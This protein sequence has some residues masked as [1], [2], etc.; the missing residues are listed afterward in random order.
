MF[1][2]LA[3]RFGG[4]AGTGGASHREYR[5]ILLGG[6]GNGTPGG[7]IGG[8]T[9]YTISTQSSASPITLLYRQ[10]TSPEGHHSDARP[11]TKGGHGAFIS[12][13]SSRPQ[14]TVSSVI[15]AVGG[16]GGNGRSPSVPSRVGGAG[17]G[18]VGADGNGNANSGGTQSSGGVGDRPTNPGNRQLGSSGGFLSAG[19]GGYNQ[20]NPVEQG[21]SGG[22][23]F[24]GGAGG[25]AYGMHQRSR[26]GGG[27][28]GHVNTTTDLY[29][30]GS[31]TQGGR[32]SLGPQVGQPNSGTTAYIYVTSA[33]I[34]EGTSG[35]VS[36][37][38]WTNLNVDDTDKFIT[39]DIKTGEFTLS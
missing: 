35:P 9:D 6:Y 37:K 21:G 17:G 25:T 4:F 36:S 12:T 13:A 26:G 16:A 11:A 31:T 1:N 8:G 28:S 10:V 22:G 3:G 34:A 15:A 19:G 32:P 5:F 20:H 18:P 14:V 24:Y 29:V 33:P 27:G 30:T 7:A 23:G 38:T 2:T 39:L